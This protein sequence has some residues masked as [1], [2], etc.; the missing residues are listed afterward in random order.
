MLLGT[1]RG[2]GNCF[3]LS[4]GTRGHQL[5]WADLGAFVPVELWTAFYMGGS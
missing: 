2:R 1:G 3:Y 5:Q 4:G